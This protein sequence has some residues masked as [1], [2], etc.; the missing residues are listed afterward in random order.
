MYLFLLY[1]SLYKPSGLRISTDSQEYLDKVLVPLL[2]K[3]ILQYDEVYGQVI[4]DYLRRDRKL[5]TVFLKKLQKYW[6]KSNHDTEVAFLKLLET[7]TKNII[8]MNFVSE[9]N[10]K[11]IVNILVSIIQDGRSCV[12][13]INILYNI[14]K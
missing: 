8:D 11:I 3:D 5:N 10:F 12:Y 9:V 14:C 6:P 4:G 7:V 2:K 1:Y 13:Y